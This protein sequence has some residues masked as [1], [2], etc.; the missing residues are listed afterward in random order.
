MKNDKN[1]HFAQIYS[2][3]LLIQYCLIYLLFGCI[4]LFVSMNKTIAIVLA[5]TSLVAFLGLM[6]YKTEQALKKFEKNE[7]NNR[8]E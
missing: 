3:R 1:W 6:T 5:I 8:N 7:N 2:T 4:G